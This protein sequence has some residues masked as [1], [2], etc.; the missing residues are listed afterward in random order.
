MRNIILSFLIIINIFSLF[1]LGTYGENDFIQLVS[2]RVIIAA[3]SLI[4]SIT[5]ILVKGTK[6]MVILSIVTA[7]IA[8]SHFLYLV[9]VSL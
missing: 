5:Y 1:E 7:L 6:T 2:V 4:L 3:V 9:Y 8:L